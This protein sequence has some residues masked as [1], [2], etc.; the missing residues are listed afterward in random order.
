[1]A[2][3]SSLS[4]SF[5][6]V[7]Y[8]AAPFRWLFGS[9]RR[10]LTA[11][12]LLLVMIV[13]PPVWW[14]TQLL[15]L[16]DIGDPF[17]VRAF[18]S[19]TIPD[20]HNA[21]VLY[22]QAANRLKPLV[23]TGKAPGE[24]IDPH[25]GWSEAGPIVRHWVDE[26]G[27]ALEVFRQGTA[28]P[29][30]LEPSLAENPD[31]PWNMT[32][33]FRT[34]Q[35][36]ALLEAS[37]LEEQGETAAA[38]RWYR[39]A[40]RATYHMGLRGTIIT[41]LVGQ[42]R[43]SELRRRF[44]TWAADPR[45][46]PELIRQAIDDVNACGSFVPSEL[47]TLKAEYS[48]AET[49][50]KDAYN[51]G[52][53]L[54]IAKLKGTFGSRGYQLESD[55]IRA[56]ADAWLSWRRDRER[57]CRVIRLAVANWVAYYEMPPH[58]RPTPDANVSGPFDFYAFGPDAP[59]NAGALSPEALDRWLNTTY[60]AQEILRSWNLRTIRTR[61]RANHRAL[62]VLLATELYRRDHRADP[63]SDEAL[64]GPYLDRLPD[65]GNM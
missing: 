33:T 15:G 52:R 56:L 59:A 54:L 21:F 64:V 32:Q 44:S 19:L 58:R 31:P 57:S 4:R 28:R 65:D 46:S 27:E 1:M 49:V 40:L 29:D 10:V 35:S 50:F 8:L 43:G 9:R 61:E 17:D 12:A 42:S 55:Q 7:K 53:Q 24:K 2:S 11:A 20:E 38:W 39:A 48:C 5:P 14:A 23:T 45:T 6:T 16:P 25:A 22:R 26:N 63:P 62:L 13:T 47:Y 30:A 37:R 60:D 51:P 3:T 34:F 41:R 18:R 36:L